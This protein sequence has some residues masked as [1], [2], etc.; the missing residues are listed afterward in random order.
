[1]HNNDGRLRSDYGRGKDEGKRVKW[2]NFF[3]TNSTK[4]HED[5]CE[6]IDSLEGRHPELR[7]SVRWKR[8]LIFAQF[9]S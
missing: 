6:L 9:E 1:M 7:V 5:A 8:F 4:C 2:V 3:F